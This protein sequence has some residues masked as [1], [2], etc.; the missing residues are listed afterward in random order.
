VGNDFSE[1]NTP[2]SYR[3][4]KVEIF[5][6]SFALKHKN[7]QRTIKNCQRTK[8]ANAMPVEIGKMV[9]KALVVESNSTRSKSSASSAKEMMLLNEKMKQQLVEESVQQVLAI[10]ERK[11]N[12]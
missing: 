2:D 5:E 8:N 11:M 9:V 12:R 4:K 3:E 7:C 10:L 6:K 1:R